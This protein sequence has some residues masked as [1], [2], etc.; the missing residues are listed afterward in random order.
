MDYKKQYYALLAVITN[1]TDL[2]IDAQIKTEM[3]IIKSLGE[4]PK[5]SHKKK[6]KFNLLKLSKDNT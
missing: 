3:E 1:A 4:K 2:L 6:N 5:H